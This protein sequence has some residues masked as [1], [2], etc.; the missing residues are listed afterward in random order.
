MS[1]ACTGVNGTCGIPLTASATLQPWSYFPGDD[2]TT[3]PHPNNSL[4]SCNPALTTNYQASIAGCIPV[5]ISC[6]SLVNGPANIDT[7][8]YSSPG[9]NSDTAD[10][11]NCL[12]HATAT[13][14]GDTVTTANPPSA[15]FQ[16]VAGADNPIVATAGQDVMV[17]DSLV[18][19]PVFDT[20]NYNP[21]I[22]S[23]PIIG[24]VQL[25]LNPDGNATPPGGAVNTTVINLVGCGTGA[26]G[27]PI[28]GNGASP[29]TVR[30][31]SPQPTLP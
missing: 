1:L 7:N 28:L 23:V 20:T 3:F 17:S 6:T 19:V 10:A 8:P 2:A 25:F 11:V 21:D 30:L 13:G 12:T 27:T 9:R 22:A 4:P 5:P 15:S 31:I 26:V 24:F 29:V 14:G 18:T 16:F